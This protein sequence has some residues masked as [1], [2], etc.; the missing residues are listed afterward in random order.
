M[1]VIRCTT[2]DI[3][4]YRR[5]TQYY[6]TAENA[7]WFGKKLTT[8][9]QSAEEHCVLSLYIFIYIL[10]YVC[11]IRNN[12]DPARLQKPETVWRIYSN[13]HDISYYNVHAST[14]IL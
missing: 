9:T 4:T 2:G 11:L 6:V 5:E 12:R 1:M 14:V 13:L 10:Y 7:F 8:P 3:I